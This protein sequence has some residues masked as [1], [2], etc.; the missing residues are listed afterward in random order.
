MIIY[1]CFWKF[2]WEGRTL[3]A[4]H[5]GGVGIFYYNFYHKILL[6]VGGKGVYF[7]FQS[8]GKIFLVLGKE[9]IFI[10]ISRGKYCKKKRMI[11]N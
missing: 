4:D 7:L 10:P 1:S 6:R 9:S 5:W 11:I 8:G 3:G 2:F